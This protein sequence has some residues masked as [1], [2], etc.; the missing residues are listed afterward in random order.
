M[1][2]GDSLSSLT[3]LTGIRGKFTDS[4]VNIA[5]VYEKTTEM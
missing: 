3:F 4:Y 1:E 2:M 5:N